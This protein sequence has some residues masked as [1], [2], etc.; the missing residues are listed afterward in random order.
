MT[1]FSDI[2]LLQISMRNGRPVHYYTTDFETFYE[3][4]KGLHTINVKAEPVYTARDCNTFGIDPQTK[5]TTTAAK[6]CI[7]QYIRDNERS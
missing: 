7:L 1:K 6:S 5:P 3:W 2:K 4:T